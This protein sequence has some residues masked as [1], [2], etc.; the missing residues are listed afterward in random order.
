MSFHSH[1]FNSQTCRERTLGV[2]R[3]GHGKLAT[4]PRHAFLVLAGVVMMFGPRYTYVVFESA[5]AV[6]GVMVLVAM[7]RVF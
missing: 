6:L 7:R 2:H 4:L 5:S 1:T 3:S